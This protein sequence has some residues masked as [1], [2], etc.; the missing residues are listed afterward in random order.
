M[1]DET[2]TAPATETKP[3]EENK[4]PESEAKPAEASTEAK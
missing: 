4:A 1:T 2:A 3:T